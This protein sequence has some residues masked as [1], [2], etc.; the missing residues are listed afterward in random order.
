MEYLCKEY[1]MQRDQASYLQ[2]LGQLIEERFRD[3]ELD[4]ET[5]L[6]ALGRREDRCRD[7]Q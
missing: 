7:V 6:L 2:A 1:A 5:W 4:D 3:S